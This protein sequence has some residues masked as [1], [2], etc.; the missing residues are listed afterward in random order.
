MC[1]FTDMIMK[2]S[3][4]FYPSV[5]VVFEDDTEKVY[6]FVQ[7][8]NIAPECVTLARLGPTGQDLQEDVR[9]ENVKYMSIENE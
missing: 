5:R 4:C 8:F 9:L 2:G 1:V 6:T 7:Y 3:D